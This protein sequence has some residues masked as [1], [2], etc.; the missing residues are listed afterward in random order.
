VADE[1]GAR[2]V[3]FPAVSTGVYGYPV[4]EAAPVAVTAVRTASTG[5]E[6]VRFVLFDQATHEAFTR[7]AEASD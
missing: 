6:E 4:E 7:A 3:A 5:V 2:T 1:V